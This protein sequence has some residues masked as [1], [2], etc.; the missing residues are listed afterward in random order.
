MA[1]TA[2]LLSVVAALLAATATATTFSSPLRAIDV[3]ARPY[4]S[5]PDP[6]TLMLAR[7]QESTASLPAVPAP[8]S[9]GVVVNAN[10]SLN[11][12]AWDSTTGAACVK[13]L[14]ALPRSS[15]PSGTCICYNLPSLDANTGAFEADLRV[16]RIAEPRDAFAGVNPADIRV[17]VSYQGASVSPVSKKSLVGMGMVGNMSSISKRAAGVESPELL[18]MYMFVGQIDKD[19][20]QKNLSM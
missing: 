20:I 15:N 8:T 5:M 2:P 14:A 18:Q 7:R 16:Y 11:I 10:G 17:G 19:Q 3:L 1:P 12:T 4:A 13:H 9:P 6:P